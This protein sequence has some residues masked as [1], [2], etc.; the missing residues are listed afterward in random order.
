MW[1]DHPTNNGAVLKIRQVNISGPAALT[2]APHLELL[3]D[4][5]ATGCSTFAQLASAAGSRGG[6]IFSYV[7]NTRAANAWGRSGTNDLS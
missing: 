2:A 3:L 5:G 4:P 6:T 1:E 7:L